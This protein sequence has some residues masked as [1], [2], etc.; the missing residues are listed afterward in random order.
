MYLSPHEEAPRMQEK[1]GKNNSN[2]N[3]YHKKYLQLIVEF[4]AKVSTC[5]KFK[6]HIPSKEYIR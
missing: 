3:Y 5:H 1:T 4:K 2:R 6:N